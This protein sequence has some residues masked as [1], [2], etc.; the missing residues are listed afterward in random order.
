MATPD[1]DTVPVVRTTELRHRYGARLAL[2]GVSLD[3]HRG[4]IFALLG[5]NGGGKTTL[6]R[7]LATLLHP[8]AGTAQ[9]QGADVVAE[10]DRVRRALGVAFQAPSVD[11]VLTVY[12]NLLHQGRMYGMRGGPLRERIQAVLR[13][14]ALEDR[15]DDR[16]AQLSGGLQRRVELAKAMLHR[17]AVLL[18][19]EPSSGLDPGA[20]RDLW[21]VLDN[22]RTSGGVT[23]LLTT[24]FTDEAERCDRIAIVDRGKI[25][26]CG[27]PAALKGEIGGDVLTVATAD[28][29]RLAHA[30]AERFGIETATVDGS[31]RIEH[32]NGHAFIPQLVEAFPGEIDTITIG[33]PTLEDVFFDRTGHRFAV[34]GGEGAG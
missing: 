27:A 2:D 24:H 11:G 22:L 30:V 6:F 19:D 5:P 16:V 15:R 8:T 34:D 23:V 28:P 29:A 21:Q 10:P 1:T 25:V 31:V 7:V 13:E 33:R 4:E 14:F 17:P 18:L 20:R 26:A 9:I 32:E 3:V 12:E